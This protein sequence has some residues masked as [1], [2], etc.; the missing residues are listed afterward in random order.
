MSTRSVSD[1]RGTDTTGH[2]AELVENGADVEVTNANRSVYIHLLS[3]LYLNQNAEY[4][5]AFVSGL[6][7]AVDPKWLHLFN[8]PQELNKL[9]AGELQ[10]LDVEDLRAHTE[11]AGGY[12]SSSTTVKLF[13]KVST[14]GRRA[15]RAKD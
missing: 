8:D 2:A 10:S 3:H 4:T 7:T 14:C 12:T 1:V 6:A 11:Y 5:A 9:V 13:W 15:R